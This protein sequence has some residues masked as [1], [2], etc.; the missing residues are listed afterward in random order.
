[1][2]TKNS[3]SAPR[4]STQGLVRYLNYFIEFPDGEVWQQSTHIVGGLLAWVKNTA[5]YRTNMEAARKLISTGEYHWKVPHNIAGKRTS[6]THRM[7]ISEAPVSTNWGLNK[8]IKHVSG[9]D[10]VK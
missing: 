10:L 6:V 2:K 5:L 1:M 8:K 4:D 7:M 9:K 3:S